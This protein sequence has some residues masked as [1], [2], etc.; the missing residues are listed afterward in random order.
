MKIK[1]IIILSNEDV[2]ERF[3]DN[4]YLI[5]YVDNISNITALMHLDKIDYFIIDATYLRDQRALYKL[6]NQ[7][8]FIHNESKVYFLDRGSAYRPLTNELI[9]MGFV[10]FIDAESNDYLRYL[11]NEIKEDDYKLKFHSLTKNPLRNVFIKYYNR[12]ILK[13]ANKQLHKKRKHL[14]HFVLLLLFIA[15]GFTLVYMIKGGSL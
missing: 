13:S 5:N 8:A 15:L 3:S 6:I 10:N 2:S 9:K 14:I 11:K 4:S 1:R 12:K 7:I